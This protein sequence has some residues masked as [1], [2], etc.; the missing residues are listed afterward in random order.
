MPGASTSTIEV[1]SSDLHVRV[2]EIRVLV[3]ADTTHTAACTMVSITMP[4]NSV[5]VQ[6]DNHLH[7]SD[8]YLL[9]GLETTKDAS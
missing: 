8:S 9:A 2:R 4:A 6:H 5:H 3:T 7:K 1:D